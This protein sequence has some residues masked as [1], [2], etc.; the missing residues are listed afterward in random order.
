MNW[1]VSRFLSVFFFFSLEIIVMKKLQQN[2][3][4]NPKQTETNQ[5]KIPGN[6][7]QYC[8]SAFTASFLTLWLL[9]YKIFPSFFLI[10]VIYLLHF[11]YHLS[12]WFFINNTASRAICLADL[13]WKQNWYYLHVACVCNVCFFFSPK[14]SKNVNCMHA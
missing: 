11:L 5:P 7:H 14:H 4:Q 2:Q 8:L 3:N 13:V 12:I 6:I 1:N 10:T 9:V